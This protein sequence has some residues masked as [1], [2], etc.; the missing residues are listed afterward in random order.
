M[1]TCESSGV[2]W[3]LENPQRSKLWMHPIIKKWVQH[4][5]TQ[6][7][8]FDYCQ[9]GEAWKKSTT[10]LVFNNRKFHQGMGKKCTVS[11][12]DG[13]SICSKTGK[14]HVLL[15]GFTDD[16]EKRQY[17]TSVACPYPPPFCELVAELVCEP[18]IPTQSRK[19]ESVPGLAAAIKLEP[20]PA[21]HY[22]LHLPKHPGCTAC[23]NC[24]VQRKHCRDLEKARRRKNRETY[25][26]EIPKGDEEI[27][28]S[29][30]TT[31][32]PKK[33]GDL[34]SSD[35]IFVIKRS[36][37]STARH[38][39]TTALVVRDKATSWMAAYPS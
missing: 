16:K 27:E 11:Y 6:K 30:N 31:D 21:S 7:V 5:A 34:V 18:D 33:F 15:K 17:K 4:P 26:I 12:K 8:E 37:T 35:S 29:Q 19:D 36:S 32:Q 1:K 14:P 22:I 25:T 24:K 3:Y 28:K 20:P 23:A 38:G 39:D 13:E 10:I 2:P 9:F